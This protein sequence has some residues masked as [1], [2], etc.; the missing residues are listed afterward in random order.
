MFPE[1]ERCLQSLHADAFCALTQ[2]EADGE[3]DGLGAYNVLRTLATVLESVSSQ[4]SLFAEVQRCMPLAR[5][6]AP[7][8]TSVCPPA[9]HVRHCLWF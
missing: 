4:P 2:E 3:D 1:Q 9:P 7:L 6:Q 8:A 5:L